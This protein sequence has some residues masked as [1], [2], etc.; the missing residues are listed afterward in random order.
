MAK[1]DLDSIEKKIEIF[2][3]QF[4]SLPENILN[5]IVTY[6]P[7]LVLVSGVLGL[8]SLLSLLNLGFQPIF[9]MT[10]SFKINY[11]LSLV[12]SIVISII[13]LLSFKPLLKKQFKG[14]RLIF[15]ALL[16][17]LLP[18]IIMFSIGNL[19]VSTIAFYLLFQIKKYYH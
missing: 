19:I 12:F 7:Y 11:Y 14:W 15:Y 5:L 17:S 8:V 9:L 4:P 1:Y 10:P 6:G 3:S 2:F 13:F 18:S 16:L